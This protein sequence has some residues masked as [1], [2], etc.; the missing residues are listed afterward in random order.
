MT[1]RFYVGYGNNEGYEIVYI[2]YI[3]RIVSLV[4][5]TT[6]EISRNGYQQQILLLTN[7]HFALG[8]NV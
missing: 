8:K 2:N 1:G 6:I 7:I 4:K 5:G 3:G